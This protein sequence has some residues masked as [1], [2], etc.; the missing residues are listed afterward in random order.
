MLSC[1]EGIVV[2]QSVHVFVNGHTIIIFFSV[3]SIYHSHKRKEMVERESEMYD[4]LL[5]S[6]T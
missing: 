4:S 5:V 6:D 2:V 3:S 1:I